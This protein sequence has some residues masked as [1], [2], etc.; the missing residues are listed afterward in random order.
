MA[1]YVDAAER[2]GGIQIADNINPGSMVTDMMILAKVMDDQ[3]QTSWVTS[4]SQGMDSVTLIG[5]LRVAQHRA[6]D[7]FNEGWVDDD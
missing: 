4:Y 2:L 1:D 5:A 6:E 3:G 7:E